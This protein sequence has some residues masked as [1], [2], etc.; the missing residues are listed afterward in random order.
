MKFR[1]L[2][3][4]LVAVMILSLVSGCGKK[5]KSA[6]D[7]MKSNYIK[8]VTLGA[9]KGVEYTPA[10]TEITDD[11]IQY[12][13][14]NLIS[15]NTTENQ[16][17]DGIATMGD[18]VNI[19]FVGYIDGETFDGGDSKGAGYELTLGSGSFID[20]FE[21]QIC[22]HSPGDA[23]DVEVTFPDDYGNEDLAGKD[24]VFE[25]TLNYIIEKVE[26]EYN[27]ALVASATD[28]ATT[29]EFETA[30]REA[31]EAQ[32]A[33]SDLANDKDTVFNKVIE[34]STVSEYPE[35]EVNDRIQMVMDSVQQ[36]AEA[37]GVDID[38]YLSNY[39][40]DLDSFKDNIKTSVET[41]IREKMIVVAIADAEGITVTDEEV[42][43]KVQELLEQTGLTD[44]ETLSQQYGFKDE[45]YYYEVLYSKIYDFIY[46]N[47]VAVEASNT[48]ADEDTSDSDGLVD[49]Y[50]TTE[51]E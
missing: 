2:S 18:A 32:A 43:Q 3:A 31:Y 45:D 51:E 5:E 13:I 26:P 1:R 33:E 9:Y 44:K 8:Y 36:E 35:S 12:D 6:I 41:Y 30:K 10:H 29:D 50:G 21:D 48:D 38:T 19:D 34:D 47:A 49:D 4:V 40:Y 27:D 14:D 22:G 28:Y 37:N 15:Q 20:D 39:G 42:D 16:I 23:F 24:A 11:Y 25:T 7:E 46:E 17:M